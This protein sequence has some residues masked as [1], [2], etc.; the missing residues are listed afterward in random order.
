MSRHVAFAPTALRPMCAPV[1]GGDEWVLMFVTG[2]PG[3][4]SVTSKYR[5]LPFETI[6]SVIRSTHET[7]E[8]R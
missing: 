3:P 4:R 1:G 5:I 2:S 8:Q 6:Q 7:K